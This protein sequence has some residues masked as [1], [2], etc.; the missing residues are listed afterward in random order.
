[1]IKSKTKIEKFCLKQKKLVSLGKHCV[2]QERTDYFV[3][4][5]RAPGS[6]ND[7]LTLLLPEQLIS[8]KHNGSL[9]IPRF[10]YTPCLDA[11][12][13]PRPALLYQE[14][15][16]KKVHPLSSLFYFCSDLKTRAFY[17]ARHLLKFR[18]PYTRF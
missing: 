11:F 12:S 1:L 2:I 4:G 6:F 13:Q 10:F 7:F 15:P 5:F 16:F 18:E 9:Q 3:R 14:I 17:T 8:C